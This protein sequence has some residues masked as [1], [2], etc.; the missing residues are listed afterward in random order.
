MLTCNPFSGQ[1]VPPVGGEKDWVFWMWGIVIL[2][3]WKYQFIRV[4][5]NLVQHPSNNI[6]IVG[7]IASLVEMRENYFGLYFPI[8]TFPY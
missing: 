5:E 4:H 8:S 3:S 7:N 1:F 2:A 6:S